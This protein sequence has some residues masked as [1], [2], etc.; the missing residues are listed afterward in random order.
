AAI[1]KVSSGPCAWTAA[2]N[3]DSGSG[4]AGS[5]TRPTALAASHSA[6]PPS[7][8]ICVDPGTDARRPANHAAPGSRA[9][10]ITSRL[11]S[12]EAEDNGPSGAR[13]TRDYRGWRVACA[14]RTKIFDEVPFVRIAH[15]TSSEQIQ[16]RFPGLR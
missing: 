10:W 15:A 16:N 2:D 9:P 7:A 4:A 13:E 1:S 11:N 12:G 8:R 3:A 5:A 14:M 6:A